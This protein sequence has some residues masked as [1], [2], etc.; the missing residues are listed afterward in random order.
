[1]ENP[2][3]AALE[4]RS[5]LFTLFVEKERHARW[6]EREH[7]IERRSRSKGQ[8]QH[9][10]F[11]RY[12]CYVARNVSIVLAV[13]NLSLYIVRSNHAHAR[14]LYSDNH[15]RADNTQRTALVRQSLRPQV[16]CFR[17]CEE[18]PHKP[19]TPLSRDRCC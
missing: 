18:R 14:F 3:K 6:L 4:D 10:P 9:L 8:E 12:G 2:D 19:S 13:L 16:N 17:A 5:N 11:H 15:F 1:M 7:P